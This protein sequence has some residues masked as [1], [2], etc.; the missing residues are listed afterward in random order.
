MSASSTVKPID[1]F[2]HLPNHIPPAGEH[3]L[4]SD[5]MRIIAVVVGSL[6][7]LAGCGSESAQQNTTGPAGTPPQQASSAAGTEW[8]KVDPCGLLSTQDIQSYLGPDA[9]ATGAKSDRMGRPECV[10]KGKDL[11][12]VKITLW[13]PPAKDVIA[14]PSKKTLPVGGKTGYITSSTSAS[15]LLEVD[16]GTAFVSMDAK[17]YTQTA[18]SAADDTTCKKAATT[19][20]GVVEKLG[21]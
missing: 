9:Q 15:C 12:Q 6:L 5:H 17:S 14:A 4:P 18:P 3:P 2:R 13:Q 8:S 11:D 20:S 7:V 16:G 1:R 19:L 21:W 10:W